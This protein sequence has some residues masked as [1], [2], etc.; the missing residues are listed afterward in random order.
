LLNTTF[1]QLEVWN[2]YQHATE[3]LSFNRYKPSNLKQ[4]FRTWRVNI[5]RDEANGKDRMR[6]PWLY[7]KLSKITPNKDKTILHDLL[8]QYYQ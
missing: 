4:K 1:D 3:D 8:V 2:E 7:L 5:P 6:N